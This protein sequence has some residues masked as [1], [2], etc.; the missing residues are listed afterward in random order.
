M[1]TVSVASRN[2]MSR[3]SI[4]GYV[5]FIPIPQFRGRIMLLGRKRRKRMVTATFMQHEILDAPASNAG[6]FGG[7]SELPR[8]GRSLAVIGL[9]TASGRKRGN[10]G[11]EH[12]LRLYSPLNVL[13]GLRGPRSDA[14]EHHPVQ[15][16][17]PRRCL[18][19]LPSGG[20]HHLYVRAYGP[21]G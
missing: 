15:T 16:V 11:G 13:V 8:L 6:R 5:L 9:R 12:A 2:G 18:V 17:I 19:I 1:S 20:G 7:R 10:S 21:H 14:P 3:V 4:S